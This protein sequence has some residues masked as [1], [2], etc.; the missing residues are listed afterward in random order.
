MVFPTGLPSSFDAFSVMQLWSPVIIALILTAFSLYLLL[1]VS[2]VG[3]QGALVVKTVPT[4]HASVQLLT[5]VAEK[6]LYLQELSI[7][8]AGCSTTCFFRGGAWVVFTRTG[9]AG[10]P[11]GCCYQ[12]S[13]PARAAGR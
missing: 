3:C 8:M 1:T 9:I 7:I 5:S 12:L 6:I 11:P 10:S 4:T 2:L 13:L